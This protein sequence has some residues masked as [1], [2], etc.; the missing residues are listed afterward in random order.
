MLPVDIH[1][2]FESE[3]PVINLTVP[4][5]PEVILVGSSTMGPQGPQGPEGQWLALTQ[6]EYDALSP[7]D[8]E[9]LYVIIS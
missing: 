3:A 7:P 8:P 5:P 9:T 1:L 6:V 2:E 4:S